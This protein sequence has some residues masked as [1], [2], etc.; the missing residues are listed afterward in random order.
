MLPIL[1]AAERSIASSA[2]PIARRPAF[3]DAVRSSSYGCQVPGAAVPSP[4]AGPY[5]GWGN[6]TPYLN[7]SPSP[8]WGAAIVYDA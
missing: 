7:Q 1:S 8:R 2:G 3:C 5:Y 6:L 4:A